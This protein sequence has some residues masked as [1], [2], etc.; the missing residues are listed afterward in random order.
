M[1]TQ[2]LLLPFAG[3]T[4]IGH[5]A[6]QLLR[7]AVNDVLVVT[8]HEGHRVAAALEGAAVRIVPNPGYWEGMLSSVRTGVE[9]APE[10][11]RGIMV[12]LG[13]QPSLQTSVVDAL[14]AHFARHE[15]GIV[16]PTFEGKRGHPLVFSARFREEVLTEFD[17]EGLR[18]L[19]NAHPRSV[20]E[21][22][23]DTDTVLD[24]MDYPEDYRRE[25]RALK[26][27][28]GSQGGNE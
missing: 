11:W 28:M 24:D 12:V 10:S 6:A 17:E 21:W 22:P 19:L 13:D 14:A 15:D 8:G 1:E 2:K 26:E 16:L 23:V 18:G 5:V 3:R 9:A 20:H 25:L 7:S 4:V 27:R